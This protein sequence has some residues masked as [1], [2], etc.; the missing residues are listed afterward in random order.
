MFA[1]V[2]VVLAVSLPAARVE[3][4]GPRSTDAR[5]LSGA[6]PTALVV[7][8]PLQVTVTEG[9]ASV[10]VTAEKNLQSLVVVQ[11][12]AGVLHINT[13]GEPVSPA[14]VVVRVRVPSLHKLTLQGAVHCTATLDGAAD[15]ELSGASE[16]TLSGTTTSLNVTV[17]GA[18]VVRATSVVTN[19]VRV[20]V[21]GAASVDVGS[22]AR[23]AVS[24]S[25][26]GKVR[27]RGSP[28]LTS[29]ASRT[30]KVTKVG[31]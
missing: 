6:A 15:V 27:Y 20:T 25:G 23:L 22:P 26:V 28:Q 7:K 17:R 18:G 1:V 31:G 14:G 12:I 4:R 24:G 8:G 5:P 29:N 16:A 2:A 3:G 21:G 13:V 30:V 9:A 19:D 10:S 11:L